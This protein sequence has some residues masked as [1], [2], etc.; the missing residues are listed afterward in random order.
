MVLPLLERLYIHYTV[1]YS[2]RAWQTHQLVGVQEPHVYQHVC[3]FSA[4][5]DCVQS[6]H[7]HYW[8]SKFFTLLCV[9][10]TSKFQDLWDPGERIA[11]SLW[12]HITSSWEISSPSQPSLRIIQALFSSHITQRRETNNEWTLSGKSCLV[13]NSI[14]T[15]FL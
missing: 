4:L 5:H 10:R 12:D 6:P 13:Q 7:N 11:I 15:H 8:S 3:L 1:S 9:P 2:Y 14:P